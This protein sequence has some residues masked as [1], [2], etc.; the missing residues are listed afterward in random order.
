[1]KRNPVCFCFF[2][3]LLVVAGVCNKSNN[4]YRYI[5]LTGYEAS[6]PSIVYLPETISQLSGFVYYPRGQQ[7]FLH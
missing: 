3:L 6:N 4:V 1:M 5:Q 7:H 2:A